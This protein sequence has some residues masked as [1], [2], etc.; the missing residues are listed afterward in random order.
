MRIKLRQLA[1]ALAIWEHHSF[2]R[3]AEEQHISQPALSRSIHNLEVSLGV[4]LFD[5]DS[6]DVTLTTFGEV[7]LRRAQA[8]LIE[9]AELEREMDLMRGLGVGRFSVAMGVYAARVSGIAAVA[10]LLATHPGLQVHLETQNWRDTER[11]VR[12]RQVDLGFG[13]IAHL[14]E[15]SDLHVESVAHHQV[16]FYCRAGHPVLARGRP[17]TTDVL[18]VYPF[19]GPPIPHR[20]A[21]LFPRNTNIDEKTGDLYPP[22]V[23]E[24]LNAVCTIV[25]ATEAWAAAPPVAIEPWLRSGEIV[26]VPF[27]AP[28]LRVHYGF[29][30]LASRSVSPAAEV[31]MDLVRTVERDLE[32]RN[33]ALVEEIFGARAPAA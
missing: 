25:A 14:Q 23:V 2:R 27:Q 20:L 19:A 17:V 1:H 7:F 13:E 26:A 11:M 31:F 18:D 15:S 10:R 28:W 16:V 4:Q 22:I 21:H 6:T 32:Q 5:R 8:L 12:N 29:M 30:R 9:A 33:Q 24:D 3:A